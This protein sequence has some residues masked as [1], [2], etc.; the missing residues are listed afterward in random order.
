ML[1][2]VNDVRVRLGKIMSPIIHEQIHK[3]YT[4]YKP[5]DPMQVAFECTDKVDALVTN[6][7]NH[8][9]D[10]D[11]WISLL[12]KAEDDVLFSFIIRYH[13]LTQT[14]VEKDQEQQLSMPD[15]DSVFFTLLMVDFWKQI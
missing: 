9:Y 12:L 4:L 13:I 2:T 10:D 1:C 7:S 5:Y 15:S 3:R 6:L 14:L 11:Y 8:L